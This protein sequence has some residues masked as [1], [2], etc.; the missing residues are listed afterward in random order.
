MKPEFYEEYWK[1]IMENRRMFFNDEVNRLSH[2]L[3]GHLYTHNKYCDDTKQ[4][5]NKM[6]A[7]EFWSSKRPYGNKDVEASIAYNLGWDYKRILTTSDLPEFVRIEARKLHEEVKLE[8]R[9]IL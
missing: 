7:E 3:L 6:D 2:I 9:L 4:E 5:F 8:L 1:E